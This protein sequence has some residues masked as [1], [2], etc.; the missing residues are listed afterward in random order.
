LINIRQIIRSFRNFSFKNSRRCPVYH[1]M[2]LS[3]LIAIS[4]SDET[5]HGWADQFTGLGW[6]ELNRPRNIS[7]ASS[8][9][10][11]V[12]QLSRI[13]AILNRASP[14]FSFPQ[15]E[16]AVAT[17]GGL[18]G[19][20]G[21]LSRYRFVPGNS[22]TGERKRLLDEGQRGSAEA[23]LPVQQTTRDTQQLHGEEHRGE[24]EGMLFARKRS[25]RDYERVAVESNE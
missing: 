16:G 12:Q 17:D 18:Q 21:Q 8:G 4:W 25:I 2:C 5:I 19:A 20:Y 24:E 6:S 14:P 22:D 13:S 1:R 9:N 11:H 7:G 15:K 23:D 10:R 3:R